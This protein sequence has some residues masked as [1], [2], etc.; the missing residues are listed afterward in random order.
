[1]KS[2]FTIDL[3]LLSNLSISKSEAIVLDML[4]YI[5]KNPHFPAF[6]V[7]NVKLSEM[8]QYSRGHLQRILKI[9]VKK[10]LVYKES[11]RYIVSDYYKEVKSLCFEKSHKRIS[12]HSHK[13]TQVT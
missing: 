1:M 2:N 11:N 7:S 4:D 10:E 6:K 12:K 9:L 8:L 3:E 13:H 5:N